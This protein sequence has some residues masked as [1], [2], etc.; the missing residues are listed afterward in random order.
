MATRPRPDHRRRWEVRNRMS[1]ESYTLIPGP[2]D[3][4]ADAWGVGDLWALR[5]RPGQLDD[6]QGFTSDPEKA[7]AHIAVSSTGSRS[8][9]PTWC[10]G[11][12]PTS[13]TTCRA[14]RPESTTAT[15]SGRSSSRTAGAS[16]SDGGPKGSIR[17]LAK[18][19]STPRVPATRAA[20]ASST[21]T[22]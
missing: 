22:A 16:Y 19:P 4:E 3:G 1:G 10:S 17:G 11:T 5:R 2:A 15:S 12:P 6:G 7:R 21:I 9:T 18:G 20:T 8:T 13:H 14:S